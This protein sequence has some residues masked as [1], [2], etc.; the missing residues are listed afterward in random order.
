MQKYQLKNSNVEFIGNIPKHWTINRA[1]NVFIE[2]NKRSTTGEETLLSVSE[3]SGVSPTKKRYDDADWISRAETLEGYKICKEKNLVM[4]I[5]LAWKKGLGISSHDGIVSP[6]YCV[7]AIK[8]N[9]HPKYMHFLLRTSMYTIEFKRNSRGIIDSRLR[10]YPDRFYKIPIILPPINEQED[11]AKYLEDACQQINGIIKLKKQQIDEIIMYRKSIINEV[12]LFGVNSS[13]KEKK[14]NLDYMPKVGAT[15]ILSRFKDVA[16]LRKEKTDE[17]SE[18]EDYLELEDIEK[19]TGRIISYRDSL[20]VE[21]KIIK[22]YAGDVLFGKLRPY[23]EKYHIPEKDGKCTG[24]I[25]AFNPIKINNKF[26]KYCLA[27]PWFID[28]VNAIS[29]GAK[30]PRVNWEKQLGYIYLP[31]PE[32]MRE[33]EKIGEYLEKMNNDFITIIDFLNEQIRTLEEYRKSLIHECVT[34]KKRVVS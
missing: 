21:S 25:L 10:L 6:A 1:K 11:I 27:S 28:Y 31:L 34:G 24:E 18:V 4:N 19:E 8:N 17:K 3:Y 14:V 33:Q 20:E 13:E 5:M 22:F 32:N 23:L 29:Y 15:R 16:G 30:M 7:F 26:L 9:A 12:T 2:I